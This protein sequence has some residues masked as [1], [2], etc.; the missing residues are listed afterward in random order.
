MRVLKVFDIF[1]SFDILVSLSYFVMSPAERCSWDIYNE[2]SQQLLGYGLY[3]TGV[4]SLF[5]SALVV[6]ALV[7]SSLT[8]ERSFLGLRTVCAA[9]LVRSWVFGF[10][11]SGASAISGRWLFNPDI[12]P[13]FGF[14][15]QFASV[16]QIEAVTHLCI[17]RY[18]HAKY[19]KNGWEMTKYH[20]V[21]FNFLCWTFAFVYSLL[22]FIFG[23]T[24]ALDFTCASCALDLVLPTNYGKYLM[25]TLLFFQSVK[26]VLFMGYMLY[27]AIAI[28]QKCFDKEEHRN[29]LLFTQTTVKL[30]LAAVA[31]W[32]PV[33]LATAWAVVPQLWGAPAPQPPRALALA[34]AFGSEL[35]PG[36]IALTILC[37]NEQVRQA[38]R[39]LFGKPAHLKDD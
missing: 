38:T 4:F 19:V 7:K 33:F 13:I 18:V 26:P 24:Y 8:E 29:Q 3:I 30:T 28:E 35:N 9:G 39:G 25:A 11:F 17:E 27:H 10:L 37:S 15:K 23:G 5:M 1:M 34:A 20:Y 12:C 6:A 14:F 22:P 36:A 16:Y 31:C 21:L 2:G 32:T